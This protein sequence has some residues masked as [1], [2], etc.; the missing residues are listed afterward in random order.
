MLS[1]A[2]EQ[3]KMFSLVLILNKGL[4]FTVEN[5]NMGTGADKAAK[6]TVMKS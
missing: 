6:L 1:Q 5:N 2:A 4:F 3:F